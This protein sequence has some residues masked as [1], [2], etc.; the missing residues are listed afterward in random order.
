MCGD[1]GPDGLAVL[2][3]LLQ[4]IPDY[5]ADHGL[6]LIYAEG[7]GDE[8]GPFVRHLLSDLTRQARLD[9]QL[10]LVSRLA[11]KSALILRA[12]SLSKQAKQGD[13]IPDPRQQ[14]KQ[15]RDLYERLGATQLFNYVLYIR[16]G[17]SKLDTISAFDP[18][19]EERGFQIEPGVVVKPRN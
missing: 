12:M 4:E 14:L 19:R 18:E 16:K 2:R 6:G 3:P 17:E 15:W 13:N 9:V 5:L 1:G 10:V 11:V 7:V 8:K